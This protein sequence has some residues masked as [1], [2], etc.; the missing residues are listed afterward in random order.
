MASSRLSEGRMVFT[1]LGGR[2]IC[3]LAYLAGFEAGTVRLDGGEPRPMALR[4][5]MIHQRVGGRWLAVHR[6]GEILR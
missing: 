5:T 1:P 3:D 6:H 4:V 2:V